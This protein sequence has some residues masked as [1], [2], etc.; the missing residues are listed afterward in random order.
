MKGHGMKGIIKLVGF[1]A[2]HLLRELEVYEGYT[3]EEWHAELRRCV[4]TASTENKPV[5]LYLDDY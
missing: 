4:I 1:A 2:N 3:I 5:T